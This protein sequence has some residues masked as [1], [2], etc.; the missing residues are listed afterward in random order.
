[1]NNTGTIT[2]LTAIV[3]LML[4]AATLV[5][6]AGTFTTT[7]GQSAYAYKKDNGKGNGNG[8]TITLEK[9]KNGGSASGF[10]TAVNQECENLI[11]THPNNSTCT[12]EG[13][14]VQQIQ[15]QPH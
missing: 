10:D 6:G 15:Q 5:V 8:N 2:T 9:C 11:C 3:V 12:E 14:L 1:M 4:T 7:T 13:V